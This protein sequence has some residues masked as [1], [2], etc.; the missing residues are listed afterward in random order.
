[1]T[2]YPL[3]PIIQ[4]MKKILV[5]ILMGGILLTACAGET[6]AEETATPTAAPTPTTSAPEPTR[7]PTPAGVPCAVPLPGPEDWEVMLCE[8]FD[9]DNGEWQ[10]ETQDN[11]YAAYTSTIADGAFRVSYTAKSFAAFQRSAL[12]WFD[13]TEARNFA[14]SVTGLMESAFENASWGVAFRGDGE[15][16]F[17][18]SVTNGGAYQFE[19]YE[20]NVWTPIITPKRT[21]TIR[22]G[23][24][25]TVR[26]EAVGQDFYFTINDALV[27]DF[28]G[29]TLAGEGIQLVVSAKEGVTAEF[30][31][32]DVVVQR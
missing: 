15:N 30:T 11:P 22:I 5:L 4:A 1:M 32:D 17:L 28:S 29:G 14:L 3:K 23:E 27:D 25:N 6:P 7:E 20:D 2:A 12:T 13:V 18:F 21:N 16:F 24:A 8:T 10:T 19:I 9:A 26:I 31:F